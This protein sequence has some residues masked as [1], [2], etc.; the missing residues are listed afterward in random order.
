MT[1]LLSRQK[2]EVP[3]YVLR[4]LVLTQHLVRRLTIRSR[5]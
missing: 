1:W 5:Q 3:F 2:P 4:F